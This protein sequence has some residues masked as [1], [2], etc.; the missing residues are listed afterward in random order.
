[1]FGR[2]KTVATGSTQVWTTTKETIG[3]AQSPSGRQRATTP[4]ALG[5]PD[6]KI[7]NLHITQLQPLSVGAAASSDNGEEP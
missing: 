6:I 3:A 7:D 5:V 2:D 1:M 4:M